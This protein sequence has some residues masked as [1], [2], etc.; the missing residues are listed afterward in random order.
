M[1]VTREGNLV[2]LINVFETKPEQQ[3]AF[4]DEWI[5]FTESV[6]EEPGFIGTALHKSADGT[7]VVNYAQWRSE[8]DFDSFLKKY[9][10]QMFASFG[11]LSERIDPHLYEVIYLYERAD[12]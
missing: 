12:S 2:T 1:L 3:Q 8:A 4:I 7:R 5:R 9:R 6:K 10:V 11:P